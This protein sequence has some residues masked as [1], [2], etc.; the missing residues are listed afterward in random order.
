E[1]I[2]EASEILSLAGA[3]NI[4]N[5][6]SEWRQSGYSGFDESQQ[7]Y[8]PDQIAQ[9]RS[10]RVIPVIQE[11]LEVGK[12]EVDLGSVR[13]YSRTVETPVNETVNLREQHATINRRPTDRMATDEDLEA[14]NDDS[15]EIHEM[16]EKAVVSKNAR[17]VEEVE[18]DTEES[19]TSE[20]I[21]DTVRHTEV[22]IDRQNQKGSYGARH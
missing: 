17:V 15:I 21:E 11:E 2:E 8:T 19:T 10:G 3:E 6:I 20:T 14:F 12:R 22:K 13:V 18:V 9:E 5:R 1:R 16:A 4:D 7:P